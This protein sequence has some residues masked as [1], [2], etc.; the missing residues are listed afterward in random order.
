MS[1]G[2]RLLEVRLLEGRRLGKTWFLEEPIQQSQNETTRLQ[3]NRERII[4]SLSKLS[5]CPPSPAPTHIGDP[6]SQL[7][8]GN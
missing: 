1:Q 3:M 6:I 8:N 7:I 2:R 4:V 5:L